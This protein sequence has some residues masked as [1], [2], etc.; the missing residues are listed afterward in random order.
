METEC[1]EPESDMVCCHGGEY[2]NKFRFEVQAATLPMEGSNRMYLTGC[3]IGIFSLLRDPKVGEKAARN[4]DANLSI[5]NV[6]RCA[7]KPRNLF[8][9]GILMLVASMPSLAQDCSITYGVYDDYEPY[10]WMENGKARGINIELLKSIVREAGC[11]LTI[12][13]HPWSQMIEMLLNG[14]ITILSAS[15]TPKRMEDFLALQP[16]FIQYRI[17]IS[18]KGT[19]FIND[20]EQLNNSTVLTLRN[21]VAAESLSRA[22]REVK[23][24]SYP[25]ER[26]ALKALSA[27]EGDF[28]IIDGTSHVM[29]E[30]HNLIVAS[31][32]IFPTLY[33]FILK[34]TMLTLPS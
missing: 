7:W 25:S 3:F 8:Y 24:I 9:I 22:N 15:M 14:K 4:N 31:K 11:E 28:A 30:Y 17:L 29:D 33:G 23:L 26:G 13:S 16:A 34:K 1:I 27:G 21:S 10:E 32:P 12:V 2:C 19:V 18:R 5:A 20:L 6:R